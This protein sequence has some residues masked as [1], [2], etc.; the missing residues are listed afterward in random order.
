M[1]KLK[2]KM[3]P[4]GILEGK[5][6][7]LNIAIID[8]KD[9]KAAN[10]TPKQAFEAIAKTIDGPVGMNIFDMDA[11]TT[12]SDGVMVEGTVRFMS[13]A[14]KGKINPDFGYLEM[15]E[16]PYSEELV[17][18]EPHLIQWQKNY[19]GRKL[20]RGPD[21]ATKIIPVHNVCITGRA[22]NNNSATE[23]MNILTMEEILLPILGQQQ[24]LKNGKVILG[25]T[26][27][28]ISVGI[29]MI[30]PEKFGRIFPTRQFPAGETAHGSGIYAQTLKAEI[31]CIVAD[32]AILAENI[33]K[34]IEA[35]CV[36]GKTVGASP[37]V[38]SV[39]RRLGADIDTGNITERAYEEL[40]SVGFTKEWITEK[41]DKLTPEEIIANADDIIPGVVEGTK[42]NVPDLIKETE[43]EI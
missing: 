32:K 5:L 1:A 33:I 9:V 3:I 30:M 36:P 11:V 16:M 31:P 21:P 2:Y 37:A 38:L 13:A 7:P 42:Y 34:C 39:A 25:M 43:I 28:I 8:Y 15:A 24:I 10:V 14:D 23:M 12:T 17:K 4:E 6:I 22:S 26:G 20:F 41:V 19:A 35:G 29:G 40:A 18:E 27:G